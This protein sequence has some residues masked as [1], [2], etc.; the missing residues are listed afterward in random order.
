MPKKFGVGALLDPGMLMEHPMP[1]QFW[2]WVRCFGVGRVL[3]E[4][5]SSS[6]KDISV[7]NEPRAQRDQGLQKLMKHKISLINFECWKHNTPT[8]DKLRV[9]AIWSHSGQVW[10]PLC[11]LSWAI[12]IKHCTLYYQYQIW[13]VDIDRYS[14]LPQDPLASPV[15][16]QAIN[17]LNT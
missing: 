4:S 3:G 8:T 6:G 2:R 17:F 16:N 12:V 9:A 7:R 11:G 5:R 1:K 13:G 10:L 14:S 15:N